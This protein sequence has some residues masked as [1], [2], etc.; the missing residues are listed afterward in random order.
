MNAGDPIQYHIR[1]LNNGPSTAHGLRIT[2]TVPAGVLN[3]VWTATVSGEG[4]SVNATSGTGNIDITAELPASSA[5][6]VDVTVTG[7]LDPAFAGASFTNT[8]YARIPG[9]TADASVV[10]TQV[11][12]ASDLRVLKT[13]PTLATAGS[14]IDY[15]IVVR[16]FGPSRAQGAIIRDTVPAEILNTSWTATVAGGA[17][18]SS[19]AGTGNLI[20]LTGDIPVDSGEIIIHVTGT[21]DPA[22]NVQTIR[23][24]AYAIPAPGT[25][26]PSGAVST[27]VTTLQKEADLVIVKSGPSKTISGDSVIYTLVVTNRGL[28]DVTGALIKDGIP[29]EVHNATVTAVTT[30]GATFAIQPQTD[31]T[32][33]VSANIPAGPPHSVTIRIAGITDPAAQDGFFT[34]TAT[35][36]PPPDVI[37]TI[38]DN[39]ISTIRTEIHNDV[40]VL[41]SKTGP[42]SV[43]VK[44]SI[45]YTINVMNTGFS[46]ANGVTITDVVPAGISG[47]TWRAE[48]RGGG[49]NAVSPAS[50]SG[51]NISLNATIEGTGGSQGRILVY[52]SGVVDNDAPDTLRNTATVTSGA[53]TSSATAVT[54]VNND[55]D[56]AVVKAGPTAIAAGEVMTYVITVTNNGPAD[57]TGASIT[58]SIPAEITNVQWT[59]TVEGGAAV[60]AASGTG[61]L[62]RLTGDIPVTTGKI[63]IQ[64]RGRVDQDY[65]GT[66]VNTARVDPPAG[67][68][69]PR[70]LYSTVSTTV[71]RA[72]GLSMLKSGVDSINA[73][74]PLAY[75]LV[76]RNAGPSA[77]DT[78]IVADSI[79]SAL[80]DVRWAATGI[81]G[82]VIL[83]GASGTGNLVRLTA[84]IPAGGYVAVAI[85]GNTNPAFSGTIYNHALAGNNN[86]RVI[87]DT[88]ATVIS[89]APRLAIRKT[90]PA[91]AVAGGNVA[92]TVTVVNSGPST[93]TGVLIEDPVPAGLTNVRW[94]ATA[95]GAATI[96]DNGIAHTGNVAVTGTLPPGDTNRVV[97]QITGTVDEAA[98]ANII[99][100]ATAATANLSVTDSV[101]T[102]LQRAVALRLTK[103]APDT[104]FAGNNISYG[105]TVSNNGPSAAPNT[106][107]SDTIPATLTNVSW[108]ATAV[109]GATIAGGNIA[110]GSGNIIRFTADLPAGAA[111]R[112]V[113]RI[114]GKTDST[115]AGAIQN[116]AYA[117]M[118]ASTGRSNTVTT[119]V[120]KAFDI[121]IVKTG[122]AS[123]GRERRCNIRSI[124]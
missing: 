96:P 8:A 98:T 5:H 11:L 36:T 18:V 63:T 122:P 99:N 112:V 49:V 31:D 120:V 56:L 6:Y 55:A 106:I 2:D 118:G 82:A 100:I 10:T 14:R 58:D 13:G 68:T 109:G 104:V 75:I 123:A 35:V 34:N 117:V 17:S 69:D 27:V 103:T 94:T 108:T 1:V 39:N 16:N 42:S 28:A 52:V 21:I 121:N 65:T 12:R 71:T 7:I 46:Q 50:G 101:T 85:T 80:S 92:Y 43:N 87:S 30:G 93:A 22:E 4:T 97:I 53:Q 78:V 115:Y 73:G 124:S 67:V 45:F 64:V 90:G 51:N 24:T 3:P 15:R 83:A 105:F 37:E 111:N 76:V 66:L 41:V 44:D 95:S 33:R 102:A 86:Q 110:N 25:S 54:G 114:T 61:N 84:N 62:I 88:I 23:N 48:A 20:L 32:V 59:A 19:S 107:V 89:N 57:V 29:S 119:Q 72:Q 81:R 116:T 79:P 77:A 74:Q 47:V 70:P 26:D 38:P 40:G 60:S 91:L 113:V 9:I